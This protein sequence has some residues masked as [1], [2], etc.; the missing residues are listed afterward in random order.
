MHTGIFE[1]LHWPITAIAFIMVFLLMRGVFNEGNK[2]A[3]YMSA[4]TNNKTL[5]YQNVSD[6][7]MTGYTKRDILIDG[8]SIVGDVIATQDSVKVTINNS[9]GLSNTLSED[10][11]KALRN[12]GD[13]TPVLGRINTS[14]KYTKTYSYDKDGN[15]TGV[16][17]T[18]N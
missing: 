12:K 8:A 7:S 6:T 16:E 13:T 1:M 9:K 3:D 14:R 17:Y 15:L 10:E 11:R 4:E 2:T 18:L 5:V